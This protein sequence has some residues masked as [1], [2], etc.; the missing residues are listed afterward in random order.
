VAIRLARLWANIVFTDLGRGTI[1]SMAN[2]VG[3]LIGRYEI[4]A[5]LGRGAMGVVYRARDPKLDR[6]VAIKMVSLAGLEPAA[7]QEYRKRFVV[8]A[9]AAGRLSHPGI[10]TMFDV[11]EEEPEPYLIME[12]VKGQTLQALISREKRSLP[13]ST[14]LQVVQEVAE[15]LHYAHAQGV[16]HRDI[17][18]ANILVDENGHAKIADFGIAKLNQTNLTMHG[19]L[20]G[21]PAYMAPEQLSEGEVD[22]RSDLFSLG[23][24]LYYML[25]G[26]R[27]FQGNSAITVCFKL[28]NHD[29]LPVSS[30]QARLSP[31]LD[32]I[33]MRAMAKDPAQRYQ[34]GMAMA[35]DIEQLRETS[36]FANRKTNWTTTSV[37]V[38]GIPRYVSGCSAASL[39][40]GIRARKAARTMKTVLKRN[41]LVAA[42]LLAAAMAFGAS[43][44]LYRNKPSS[45]PTT[46]AQPSNP[47]LGTSIAARTEVKTEQKSP[48]TPRL[49]TKVP[50]LTKVKAPS[51]VIP[52][53]TP[54]STGTLRIEI[55]H[56]FKRAQASVWV[57]KSLV[58]QRL[59]HGDSKR[60]AFVFHKVEG[61][62]LDAVNV[63][64]GKHD[65]RVRIQSATDSYDETT[66]MAAATIGLNASILRVVCD[67][68]SGH[69][70]VR[71]E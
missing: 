13:L 20:L 66:N 5:E 11:E 32:N 65:V 56:D 64:T 57:D 26:H 22:G 36:G 62:Q 53:V 9:Q 15:A 12:Y 67:K 41:P 45:T 70:A 46:I 29:P 31:E 51:T 44:S 55:D 28:L 54:V 35:S 61:Y 52:P 25:T 1:I 38:D 7:E 43:W 21:S 40:G 59:L 71:L 30:F 14:T 69:L 4:D 68:K 49:R 27:P 47:P 16:I 8:E 2:R 24:I 48:D 37:R 23:I 42:A 63:P 18:P 34:T 39:D 19:Q 17:K 3:T 58:Y 33:V 50:P 10:V 6:I 60:R